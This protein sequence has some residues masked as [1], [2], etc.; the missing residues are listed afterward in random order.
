M[1]GRGRGWRGAKGVGR[2]WG[3]EGWVGV[4]GGGGGGE[5]VDQFRSYFTTTRQTT[6]L[7]STIQRTS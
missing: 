6:S 4:G 5:K 1:G 3:G 2:W 7:S